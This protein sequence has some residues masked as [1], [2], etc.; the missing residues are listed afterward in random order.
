MAQTGNRFYAETANRIEPFVG[1]VPINWIAGVLLPQH[2]IPQR[3]NSC[4]RNSRD[5]INSSVMPADFHLVVIFV[6]DPVNSGLNAAPKFQRMTHCVCATSNIVHAP[7][8]CARGASAN[9]QNP[10]LSG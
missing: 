4:L 1:P 5:V 3:L 2:R 6:L 10:C 7:K 9:W 8:L